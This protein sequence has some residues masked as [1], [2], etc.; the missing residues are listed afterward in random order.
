M[1]TTSWS[2]SAVFEVRRHASGKPDYTWA[3]SIAAHAT[4]AT[5]PAAP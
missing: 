2:L 4:A 5:A 1:E 3:R